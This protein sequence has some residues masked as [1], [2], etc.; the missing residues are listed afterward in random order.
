MEAQVQISPG[1]VIGVSRVILV[2]APAVTVQEYARRTGLSLSV[3]RSQV[4]DRRIPVI[5]QG[6]QVLVNL[7]ALGK[8]AIEAEVY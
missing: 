4:A 1:Q 8:Q 2:D 3:V 6:K 7:M 5:R